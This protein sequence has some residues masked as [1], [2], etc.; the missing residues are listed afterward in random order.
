MKPYS[1]LLSVVLVVCIGLV[2]ACKRSENASEKPADKPQQTAAQS[3]AEQVTPEQ[4]A[5][6]KL[7]VYADAYNAL[8]DDEKGLPAAYRTLTK[9]IG[10]A[11]PSESLAFPDVEG[12]EETLTALRQNRAQKTEGLAE[13]DAAADELIAAGDKLLGHEKE[14]VPYFKE[15]EYKSDKMA[16]AKELL[17]RLEDDYEAA[18]SALSKLGGEVLKNKRAFAEKRMEAF[19]K[20]GDMVRY[21]TEEILMLSEELLAIFDDPKVPFNRSEAFTKGNGLITR[22]DNAIR[23]QRKAT[24]DMRS[25]DERAAAY[26]DAIRN[27]ATGIIADYRE[28]RDRKSSAAFNNMLKKYDKA[29]QDYNSAQVKPV[30]ND[31]PVPATGK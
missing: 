31:Q 3:A 13:L 19:K 9:K 6:Q 22:L 25:K 27:N 20:E 26:Y 28:V 29:A 10:K 23:A 7:A 5:E 14:M 1:I 4:L 15:G 16:K 30:T 2:S 18:L 8:I 21:N 17:P 12:L 11:K 24:D